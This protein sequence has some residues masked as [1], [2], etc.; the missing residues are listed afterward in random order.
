MISFKEDETF[1][2]GMEKAWVKLLMSLKWEGMWKKRR[3]LREF[4]CHYSNF[5]LKVGGHV[6]P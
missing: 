3:K 6:V 2:V 4:Q 1:P 5:L